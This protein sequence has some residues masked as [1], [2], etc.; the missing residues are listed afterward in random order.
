[1]R[2]ISD[3]EET[4]FYSGYKLQPGHLHEIDILLSL[5]D[6]DTVCSQEEMKDFYE[7]LRRETLTSRSFGK[8]V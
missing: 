4:H 1:M 6:F 5:F 2:V 3:G 7:A 8:E